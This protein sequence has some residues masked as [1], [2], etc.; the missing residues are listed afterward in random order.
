MPSP[1]AATSIANRARKII[2]MPDGKRRCAEAQLLAVRIY[3]EADRLHLGNE[4]VIGLFSDGSVLRMLPSGIHAL[5]AE[6]KPRL[7]DE[8]AQEAGHLPQTPGY[9]IQY[10]RLEKSCHNLLAGPPPGDHQATPNPKT[11]ADN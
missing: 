9:G 4:D 8:L 6:E 1:T 10:Q 2:R 3:A 7:L 5:R 11:T